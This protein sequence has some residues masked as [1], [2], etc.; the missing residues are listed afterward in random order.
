MLSPLKPLDDIQP[1]LVC[2]LLT[3]MGR[4]TAFFG[5]P[6]GALGRGQISFNFNYEVDFNDF[7]Y[8]TLCVFS[9]MKD[10]KHTRRDFHY[11]ACV[12]LQGWDFVALGCPGVQKLFFKV[13][14]CGISTRR[15]WRAEQNA[16]K[17][18]IL[19]SNWWP[20]GVVKSS[21]IIFIQNF[22]CVL[23]NRR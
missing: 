19:G 15:G 14:S 18:F 1:N 2:E 22:V 17:I 9:Q 21:N 23:T 20:W 3:W 16:S 12:M 10:T 6:P 11:V 4:A 8:Q 13:W 5:P 7:L